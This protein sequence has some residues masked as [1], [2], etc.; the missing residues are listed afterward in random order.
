M[1]LL[2]FLCILSCFFRRW[3]PIGTVVWSEASDLPNIP[4]A[5]VN[6]A[7]H[8]RWDGRFLVGSEQSKAG[9]IY[10]LE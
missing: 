3:Q 1:V 2:K 6:D 9:D 4:G 8:L 7:E 10:T 5:A